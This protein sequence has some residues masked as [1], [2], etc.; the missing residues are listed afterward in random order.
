MV[1]KGPALHQLMN[2]AQGATEETI[3]SSLLKFNCVT[4]LPIKIHNKENKNGKR[5]TFFPFLYC[6]YLLF[7]QHPCVSS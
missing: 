2:K 5:G 1:E 6:H 7:V 4:Y 3:H